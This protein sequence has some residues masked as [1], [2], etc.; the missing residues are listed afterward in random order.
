MADT[1]SIIASVVGIATSVVR[2][3]I[4]ELIDDVN[5]DPQI[6][7]SI[8]QDARALYN[9]VF[10]FNVA[11]Q[12]EDIKDVL[13]GYED[14]IEVIWNLKSPQDHCYVVLDELMRKMPQRIKSVPSGNGLLLSA[15]KLMWA[16]RTKYEVRELQD[17]RE[18]S[19]ATLTGALGAVS[20]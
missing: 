14:I 9:L 7:T 13:S 1:F 8:S 17:Q 15:N 11:L 19:K 12:E 2:L 3:S 4:F 20:L 5:G 6:I 18:A 16:I 10:S